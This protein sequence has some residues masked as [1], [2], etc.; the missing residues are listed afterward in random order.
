MSRIQK[1]CTYITSLSFFFFQ[2]CIDGHNVDI[3][4]ADGTPVQPYTTNCFIIFPSERYDVIVQPDT[5]GDYL[6]RFSTTEEATALSSEPMPEFP[7]F[8][9]AIMRVGS[10][11]G[12]LADF[13]PP[14]CNNST[15][16]NCGEEYVSACSCLDGCFDNSS[17]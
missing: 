6:I 9:Y 4:A 10:G 16:V 5:P 8:G 1:Q 11:G 7:H 15:A 17:M 13:S 2:V 3:I 12:L 14:S